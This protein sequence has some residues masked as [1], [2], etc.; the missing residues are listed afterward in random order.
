M[1]IYLSIEDFF[2]KL[3][4]NGCHNG[5]C[6]TKSNGCGETEVIYEKF[7]PYVAT[8]ITRLFLHVQFGRKHKI[9]ELITKFDTYFADGNHHEENGIDYFKKII[10]ESLAT[11]STWKICGK[12]DVEYKE[13]SKKFENINYVTPDVEECIIHKKH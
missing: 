6:H 9:D 7:H 12:C 8:P 13:G 3:C 4:I 11:D 1:A 5:D 2:I 10:L